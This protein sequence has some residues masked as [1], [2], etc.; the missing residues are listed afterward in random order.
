MSV[1]KAPPSAVA[2]DTLN[3]SRGNGHREPLRFVSREDPSPA[4]VPRRMALTG[5]VRLRLP[6]PTRVFDSYWYL[7]A[8]RQRMFRLHLLGGTGPMTSD[9]ILR[10]YRFTN[11]YRASDRTTQYLL[12]HVMY[13]RTNR[14]RPPRSFRDTFVRVLL[15]KIF[16]KIETWEGLLREVGD[17]NAED[18]SVG[19]IGPVLDA[20]K[21]RGPVYSPAY[22]MPS[23]RVFGLPSK[24][25]NHL[26]LIEHMLATNVDR[27]IGSARSMSEAYVALIAMPSIGPFLAYQLVTDLNYSP[28]LDFTETEFVSP[29]PGA[30]DGL[31]KCF[32]D[33][34]D[35]SPPDIVR[36]AMETQ[37]EQLARRGIEFSDLWGR[38]LQL[39]DC[40]NLFCETDKYSRVAHPTVR[41]RSH[42]MKIKQRYVPRTESASAWYPPKWGINELVHGWLRSDPQR[43]LLQVD[44][45]STFTELNE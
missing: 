15:F 24:H 6:R 36:Y 42:R 1:P 26:C 37:Q 45:Q 9:P 43:P 19:R 16:N 2:V 34:G 25:A 20:L 7:A 13:E 31:S 41:G 14:N 38:P 39:V 29:G 33:P 28:S 12:Q 32:S 11:A 40:Q 30:L 23:P 21:A 17:I 35:L 10:K 3:S 22:I 27:R 44:D 18:F 8:E 5:F 4:K